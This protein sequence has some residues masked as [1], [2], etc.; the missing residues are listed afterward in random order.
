[1]TFDEIVALRDGVLAAVERQLP[2]GCVVGYEISGG[3]ES[4]HPWRAAGLFSEVVGQG[5]L[6]L[7]ALFLPTRAVCLVRVYREESLE[8][9][10]TAPLETL[11]VEEGAAA[12]EIFVTATRGHRL[13]DVASERQRLRD[14]GMPDIVET[15]MNPIPPPIP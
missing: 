8:V 10:A 9:L 7:E 11:D 12:G 13:V 15:V 5:R 3:Q 2:A 4:D 1:M 6:V 14:S